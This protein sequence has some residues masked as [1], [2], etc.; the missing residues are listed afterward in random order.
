MNDLSNFYCLKDQVA[1]DLLRLIN[2]IKGFRKNDISFTLKEMLFRIEEIVTESLIEHAEKNPPIPN[3]LK[4]WVENKEEK[5]WL[6][7]KIEF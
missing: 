6:I 7:S 5:E 1:T 4:E 3:L 2:N